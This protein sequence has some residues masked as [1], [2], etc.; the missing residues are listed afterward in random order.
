M[1]FLRRRLYFHQLPGRIR[2]EVPGLKHNPK[3]SA[4][5]TDHLQGRAGVTRCTANP[6]T[7]RVL[8]E[9]SERQILFADIILAIDSLLNETVLRVTAKPEFPLD[10]ATGRPMLSPGRPL[11]NLALCG[12]AFAALFLGCKT[13]PS[14]ASQAIQTSA[15][16]VTVATAYPFFSRGLRRFLESNRLNYDLLTGVLVFSL[17]VMQRNVLGL[18]ISSLVNT[19]ALIRE[20]SQRFAHRRIK[21]MSALLPQTARLACDGTVKAVPVWQL[22]SGDI[23]VVCT[24]EINPADGLIV[25][26]QAVVDDNRIT[27]SPYPRVRLAGEEVL[28]GSLIAEGTI[29]LQVRH[30]GADT[31][32][33]RITREA[34]ASFNIGFAESGNERLLSFTVLLAAVSYYF[35]GNLNRGIAILLAAAPTV[36]DLAMPVSYLPFLRQAMEEGI[37][38]R[39]EEVMA[40]FAAV[41]T[42]VFDKTGTLTVPQSE[43]GEIVLFDPQYTKEELLQIAALAEAGVHHPVASAI[44]K[45]AAQVKAGP[46]PLAKD[47]LYS[48][49]LGVQA[50]VRGQ[51]VLIGNSRLMEQE[52]L[53]LAHTSGRARRLAH[54]GLIPVYVA[55]DGQIRGIIGIRDVVKEESYEAINQLR[56]AGIRDFALISGDRKEN[57]AQLADNLEMDTALGNLLPQEKERFIQQLKTE[58]QRKVAM[59][60]DGVNDAVAMTAS[61]VGVALGCAAAPSVACSGGI[62]IP[63]EDPR[64]VAQALRFS[65]R[66]RELSRQNTALAT[67]L[68]VVGLSLGT[69]GILTPLTA[70]LFANA[71]VMAVCANTVAYTLRHRYKADGMNSVKVKRTAGTVTNAPSVVPDWHAFREQQVLDMLRTSVSGLSSAERVVR[72]SG[73]GRNTLQLKRQTSLWELFLEPFR[74]FMVQVLLGA[75]VASALVGEFADALIIGGIIMLEASLGVIQ[76]YR[77]ERSLQALRELSAP[78]A[79]VVADGHCKTVQAEELVPGDIIILEAGD[80]VPADARLLEVT[81]FEVEE[82]SLTGEAEPVRKDPQMLSAPG[83]IPADRLSMVFMGTSV[84]KGRAKAVIVGTGMNTQM[85]QVA[86]MLQETENELTPLQIQLNTMGKK[87]T[88]GC[89]AA[90]VLVVAIGLLRGRPLLEMVRTGVSLAVGAIPEGLPAVVTIAMAFGVHRMV[91]KNIVVRKLSAVE[92]LGCT[93]V[94][95]TDKTGTLT[96]N[97]MT[98]TDILGY[99]RHWHVS[100]EGYHPEGQLYCLDNVVDAEQDEE[101][102]KILSV[103]TLC[104]NADY[105]GNALIQGDP[106]EAA[107]LVA[108]VKAGFPWQETRE[109]FCREKEFSFDSARRIMSVICRDTTGTATLYTKGAP[110]SV[111]E[112]C[113]FIFSKRK[114]IK[115]TDSE[116]EVI[117]SVATGLASRALRVLAVAY[118]PVSEEEMAADVVENKLI[119]A[120]LIGMADPV[121]AGVQE[122]VAKCRKAGVKV[123]MITGDHPAT[124]VAVARQLSI[125][126]KG[127]ILTGSE[128]ETMNEEDLGKCLEETEIC[129]RT[130]PAQKLRLVRALKRNGHIVAMTG[131]GINDAPAVK[132]ANV[133][134]AMGLSGTEVT[135]GASSLVLTDDNFATIVEALEEGRAVGD[136]IRSTVRYLLPGNLGE[137]MAI[138]CSSLTGS[139]LPLIPSQILF[140][141]LITESIPAMALGAKPP[142][143]GVLEQSPRKPDSSIVSNGLQNRILVR[144]ILTGLTTFGVF[145]LAGSNLTRARTMAFANLVTSQGFNLLNCQNGN[146][147]KNPYL[148]PTTGASLAL[149][150]ATLYVP[151][152]RPLFQTVPLG[153][154][155]W[156]ILLAAAVLVNKAE[157][158]Y[159]IVTHSRRISSRPLSQ[160][161]LRT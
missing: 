122:A 149:T 71:G 75:G 45:E 153:I 138:L 156:A 18:A 80:Q 74:D 105:D 48:P 101:L 36:L 8:V 99:S 119:F 53:E 51:R 157:N 90:C 142:E 55:V 109:K 160:P 125:L 121:K 21:E 68:A 117:Q 112:R 97:E 161:L 83:S 64:K 29:L 96:K 98:V 129:A 120:G 20:S 72:L 66:A 146:R 103:A 28:A 61:D 87:V 38:F 11:L 110:G 136:N 107:L 25:S 150:L 63:S 7:G 19:I 113:T 144:G 115:L 81:D 94:I 95:C 30:V 78:S 13:G 111:L 2:I 79:V 37:Y 39:N 147:E 137:M 41:D 155:D 52:H 43:I 127:G 91:K 17:L 15:A 67:G 22:Q 159:G 62:I 152:I 108:A 54:L 23:F 77:A 141:N 102:R 47:V 27:G 26:G 57:T 70:G 85:G 73:Y 9:F 143:T 69:A 35:S 56:L 158:A 134:I 5:I 106:T 139:A 89:L 12:A 31:F 88:A 93:T 65:R 84:V 24:G 58:R 76:G 32:L 118:R 128:I 3:L 46:A 135:K 42:A 33:A 16:A 133:G 34:L 131:D 50:N 104:N 130:T 4:Q 10:T 49:G 154:K 6:L 116:R 145:K 148:L 14:S 86:K 59:I 60:G 151:F 123:L 140:V 100:G 82:A 124:A 44:R 126:H 1:L 92:T 114:I 40:A 132:E